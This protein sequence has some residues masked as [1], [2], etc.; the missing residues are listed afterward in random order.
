M[1]FVGVLPSCVQT[2]QIVKG[3][4]FEKRMSWMNGVNGGMDGM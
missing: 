1:P 3:D 2:Q 4:S